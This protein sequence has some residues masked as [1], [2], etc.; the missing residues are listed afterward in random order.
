MVPEKCCPMLKCDK[1]CCCLN[2]VLILYG[3]F[4]EAQVLLVPSM[5]KA[6]PVYLEWFCCLVFFFYKDV[7]CAN[8]FMQSLCDVQLWWTV[9]L[10][11][12]PSLSCSVSTVTAVPLYLRVLYKV[13][14][15]SHMLFIW[16]FY[17]MS[18]GGFPLC[19]EFDYAV[20]S[21]IKKKNSHEVS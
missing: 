10:F 19:T 20:H 5:T 14:S 17:F 8:Y 9:L 2:R 21:Q 6:L 4:L 11:C 1:R 15:S 3:D 16:S 12:L 18:V 7:L 13:V